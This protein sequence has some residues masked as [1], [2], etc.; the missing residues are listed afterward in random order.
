MLEM[1]LMPFSPI[2]HKKERCIEGS[3]AC[4]AVDALCSNGGKEKRGRLFGRESLEQK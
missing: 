3:D 4:N 2:H 1:Q